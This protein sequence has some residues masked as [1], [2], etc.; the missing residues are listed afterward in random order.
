MRSLKILR[1]TLNDREKLEKI[2]VDAG[3][4]F[5]TDTIWEAHVEGGWYGLREISSS[6]FWHCVR[7]AE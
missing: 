2:F 6:V 5:P 4:A 7:I 3:L 1:E